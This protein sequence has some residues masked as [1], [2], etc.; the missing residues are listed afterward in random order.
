VRN[1]SKKSAFT[2]IALALG[3]IIPQA[4]APVTSYATVSSNDVVKLRILETTDLHVNMVN[5]DYFKDAETQKFGLAKTATLIKQAR[6]E[7]KNSMLFD[8]GDL[9]QGNPLGDYVAKINPLKDG[10]THPVF[11]AMNLLTYDAANIGNHEFNYGLDFLEMSLKGAKFPYVNAN[12]YKDDKDN[13]PTN[14]QNYFTPYLILDKE[15]IDE[16]GKKHSIKVGVIGFVPPQIMQWDKKNLEGKVIA[17]DIV[18]TAKKF[19]PE[20]KSKGADIIV[21]IPHSGVGSLIQFSLVLLGRA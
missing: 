16:A 11:K 15:V 4:A 2:S 21:A 6:T 12:V 14:D 18:E 10:D 9:I 13:D 3:L 1:I 17:K 5:Y 8:N 19:I 20:M 7:V